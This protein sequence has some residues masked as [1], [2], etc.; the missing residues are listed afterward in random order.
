MQQIYTVDQVADRFGK[1]ARTI[2]NWITQGKLKAKRVGKSYIVTEDA[3]HNMVNP[4][5]VDRKQLA[6]EFIE[7]M[8]SLNIPS[9]TM[10][11]IERE[12][13]EIERRE[14]KVR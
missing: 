13:L 11:R 1:S 3:I 6:R 12:E 9:G 5:L 10:D 8:Q 2:R 14:R 4:S 7:F